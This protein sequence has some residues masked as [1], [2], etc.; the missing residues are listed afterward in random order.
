MKKFKET[1]IVEYIYDNEEERE[2]HVKY[3]E[4]Q[5]WECSGQVQHSFGS[6]WDDDKKWFWYGKF[7]KTFK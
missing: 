3:M 1:R 2:Q 7:Y 4:S 5:G 6:I